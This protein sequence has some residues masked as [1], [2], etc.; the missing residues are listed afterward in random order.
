MVQ[1][2][3]QGL[4]S[5][6]VGLMRNRDGCVRHAWI[7]ALTIRTSRNIKTKKCV[8]VWCDGMRPT[9]RTKEETH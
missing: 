8:C 3:N 5:D 4:L 1:R 2:C 7:F 6:G 9:S